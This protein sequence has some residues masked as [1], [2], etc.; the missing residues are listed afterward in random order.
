MQNIISFFFFF[1]IKSDYNLLSI[2]EKW[3]SNK[4]YNIPPFLIKYNSQVMEIK[5]AGG[6]GSPRCAVMNLAPPPAALPSLL[7]SGFFGITAFREA[8]L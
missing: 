4:N 7:G 8:N 2:K 6:S 1:S 3:I 5:V